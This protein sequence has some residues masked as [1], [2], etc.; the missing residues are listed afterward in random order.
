MET[1]DPEKVDLGGLH[2]LYII[3]GF[4]VF[5][6]LSFFLFEVSEVSNY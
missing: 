6:C 2:Y 5:F 3:G 1:T 4:L